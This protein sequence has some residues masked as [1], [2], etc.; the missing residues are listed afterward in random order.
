MI[1]CL[2]VDYSC[3]FLGNYDITLHDLWGSSSQIYHLFSY[4]DVQICDYQKRNEQHT[5]EDQE[6]KMK[7]KRKEKHKGKVRWDRKEEE[8]K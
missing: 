8:R 2:N 3:P 5:S 7:T 1:H 4:Y 6:S